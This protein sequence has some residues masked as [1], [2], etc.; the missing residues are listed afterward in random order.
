MALTLQQHQ[1]VEASVH[2]A[3][4]AASLANA[5]AIAARTGSTSLYKVD[6]RW[7][8][9][10]PDGDEWLYVQRQIDYCDLAPA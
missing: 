1:Q 10:T 2:G 3:A 9:S 4:A 6:G 5:I 8:A 7:Q